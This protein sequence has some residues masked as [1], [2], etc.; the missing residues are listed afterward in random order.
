M[1]STR[2]RTSKRANHPK[3][4]IAP[5]VKVSGTMEMFLDFEPPRPCPCP[6]RTD[7]ED[8]IETVRFMV[9]WEAEEKR[10]EEEAHKNAD[11]NRGKPRSEWVKVVTKPMLDAEPK[12]KLFGPPSSWVGPTSLGSGLSRPESRPKDSTVTTAI[13]QVKDHNAILAGDEGKRKMES[14]VDESRISKV[15]KT[16]KATKPIRGTKK[17]KKNG[18]K[19]GIRKLPASSFQ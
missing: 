19:K 2:K 17:V 4:L 9:D 7:I 16:D 12:V 11:Y 13:L 14:D 15:A 6:N 18:T 8:D 10:L 1:V 3:V 5:D